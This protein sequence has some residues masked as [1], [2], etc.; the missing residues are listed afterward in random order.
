MTDRPRRAGV[1]AQRL[2]AELP[3]VV[4]RDW[5]GMTDEETQLGD[6]RGEWYYCF[7]HERVETRGNCDEMDRMGP[8]PTRQDAEN[9]R[10]QVAARN[11][12]WGEEDD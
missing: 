4:D 5:V 3:P 2:P 9:W 6:P 8:Y 7:K 11:E 1:L 10:A 12:A